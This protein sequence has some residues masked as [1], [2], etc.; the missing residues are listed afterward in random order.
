MEYKIKSNRDL[1][2]IYQTG[3][4][5]I[6]NYFTDGKDANKNNVLHSASCYW[7]TKSN[8][9]VRKYFFKTIEEAEQW[10]MQNIGEQDVKWKK[11]GIC[12][13]LGQPFLENIEK[14]LK[15][16]SEFESNDKIED[17]FRESK[18]QKLL[19]NHLKKNG[20]NVKEMHKINSGILDI[21][22]DKED[23]VIVIEVKGEDKGGYN[24]AEMNFKMGIGQI[25]SRMTSKHAKYA[26]AIPLTEDYKRVLKKYKETS[27]FQNLALNFFVVKED[28]AIK[29]YS[30]DSFIEMVNNL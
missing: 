17:V 24:S 7:I 2:K 13:A 21:V 16:E 22:A 25:I 9:N 14:I 12:S 15:I 28:G 26:L 4:G 23:E 5:F 20:Y 11:C 27:G 6:F 3:N 29:Y 10:L 18:V 1:Y 19:V 30:S 8:T